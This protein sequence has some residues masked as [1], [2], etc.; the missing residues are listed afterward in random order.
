MTDN[1]SIAEKPRESAAI[2]SAFDDRLLSRDHVRRVA[3]GWRLVGGRCPAC[4]ACAFPKPPICHRCWSESVE[5]VDLSTRGTL[6]SYSVVHVGPAPWK[7]P[8]VL[9]YVDLDD[10]VRVLAHIRAEPPARLAIGAVVDLAVAPVAIVD[11][12]E[13]DDFVF[14]VAS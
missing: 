4:G 3:D 7:L 9:G 5:A 11:G 13:V 1:V 8:Y 2:A 6:Y 12:R 14:D 10:D